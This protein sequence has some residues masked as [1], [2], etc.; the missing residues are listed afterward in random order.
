M[1]EEGFGIAAAAGEHPN[2]DK[3]NLVRVLPHIQGPTLENYIIYPD[4]LEK[5]KKIQVFENFIKPLF[6]KFNVTEH[7]YKET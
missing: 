2:I 1:A 4:Y 6:Q 5:S 7:L 3:M